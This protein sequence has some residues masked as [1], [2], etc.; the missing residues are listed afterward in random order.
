M[1]AWFALE[2]LVTIE[3]EQLR[4]K[5]AMRVATAESQNHHE[6]LPW[7]DQRGNSPEATKVLKRH[8]FEALTGFRTS[9][10]CEK[11]IGQNIE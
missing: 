8:V 10:S 1:S 11:L 3:F 7:A 9:E 4:R 6:G 2:T 5:A